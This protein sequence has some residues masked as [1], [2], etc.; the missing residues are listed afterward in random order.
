MV[1]NF[2]KKT[3]T[4]KTESR[5]KYKGRYKSDSDSSSIPKLRSDSRF[6]PKSDSDSGSRSKLK[7]SSR[8]KSKTYSNPESKPRSESNSKMVKRKVLH[9]NFI[10]N[11]INLSLSGNY[12]ESD[13]EI[14]CRRY[15]KIW[16]PT[17]K[18]CEKCG[19][20]QS[21]MQGSGLACECYDYVEKDSENPEMMIIEHKNRKKELLRVSELI[22]KGK[23]KK[24]KK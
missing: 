24:L 9:L 5:S 23:L 12:P 16:S 19:Y 10:G 4:S 20:L 17:A 2:D 22:E 13:R 7:T 3:A 8:S 1:R 6:K 21:W 18:A 11:D 14:Y 15:H